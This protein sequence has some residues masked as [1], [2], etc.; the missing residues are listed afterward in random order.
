MAQ[1]VARLGVVMGLDTTEFEQ[2]LGSA[3]TKVMELANKIPEM[4]MA[5]VVALSAMAVHALE[6]SDQISDL[7]DAT[8]I[9]I[10]KILQL[11]DA[12]EMSGGHFDDA[13]KTIEKFAQN[14]NTAAE[15]S[16]PLQDAFKKAGISL[17]D[18]ASMQTEDLLK[19]TAAG[20]AAIGDKATQTGE[21]VALFGKGM[22]GVDMNAFSAEL[23]KSSEEYDRYQA[24]I[25]LTADM[26][27]RLAKKAMMLT[28]TFTEHLM[29]TID[30]MLEKWVEKGGAAEMIFDKLH[31]LLLG[32]WY[33]VGSVGD[34]L[35]VMGA[36][37]DK[38]FNKMTDAQYQEKLRQIYAD[39]LMFQGKLQALISSPEYKPKDKEPPNRPV[40]AAKDTEQLKQDQMYYVA[41]L[42]SKEYQRQVDFSIQQLRIRD[43]MLGMTTNE[44]T[45]QEAVNQQLDRTSQKINE[46]TKQR[47]A[48]VGRGADEKVLKE[49]DDQIKKVQEIGDVAAQT[50]RQIEVSSIASQRTFSFGWSKAFN[51]FKEDAGNDAKIAEDLFSSVTSSMNSAIDNFVTTGKASFA[52]LAKSILQ[53]IEKII[54]KAL[55]M[56]A[57]T[58]LSG[59]MGGGGFMNEAGGMEVAGSLGFANGGDPPVGVPSMVGE[60]GPEL[61]IP[62]SAG[63]VIPNNK[64]SSSFGGG[65]GTTYNGPY[66]ASMSAIDTQSALQFIAKNQN[67]IWAA[68]Q[69]AQRSLP[70]SR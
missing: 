38:I 9:S 14:I 57:I 62:R 28:L 15:G 19:K 55:L 2:A 58:G 36:A 29:P 70:Q 25:A 10:S 51:Q 33:A 1:N 7:S 41:T 18:L 35:S 31:K 5:G 3:K 50:A 53:D 65:G 46:I 13:N 44:K 56:K 39:H 47:E 61:F 16:K 40:T 4:A 69:A 45:I 30:A 8:G 43:S 27:D 42:I 23:Q 64:L 32:L 48:A 34:A 66:I 37:W 49:Y 22:K 6:F 11:S 12:L 68:N 24:A 54:L 60:N 67:S 20:I 59:M 26:H 63:T 17:Q 52:D 21:K